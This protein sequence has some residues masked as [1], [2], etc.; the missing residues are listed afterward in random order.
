MEQQFGSVDKTILG[1]VVECRFLLGLCAALV[2]LILRPQ[3][4]I[5]VTEKVKEIVETA[6]K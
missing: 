2:D 5:I 6:K 4:L 1:H 3:D